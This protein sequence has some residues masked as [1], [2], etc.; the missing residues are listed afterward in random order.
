MDSLLYST[1]PLN[2]PKIFHQLFFPQ[3]GTDKQLLGVS[4]GGTVQI[5]SEQVM[6]THLNDEVGGCQMA[7]LVECDKGFGVPCNGCQVSAVQVSPTEMMVECHKTGMIH[8][9][10]TDVNIKGT[11]VTKVGVWDFPLSLNADMVLLGVSGC[12]EWKE[13]GS[14]FI[15]T[16]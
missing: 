9:L 14:L 12:M 16:G 15:L 1:C 5:L 13:G 11:F 4:C 2:Y 6:N 8:S 10:R 7:P 3:W